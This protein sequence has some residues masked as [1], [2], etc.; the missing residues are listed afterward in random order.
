MSGG[1]DR[2]G[3]VRE[4]YVVRPIVVV[5][6]DVVVEVNV[7]VDQEGQ[8]GHREGVQPSQSVL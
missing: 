7:L 3:L 8:V 1:L 4:D 2:A 5:G 6:V